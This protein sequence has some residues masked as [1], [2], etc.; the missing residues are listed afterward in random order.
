MIF[1]HIIH[2]NPNNNQALNYSVVFSKALGG[3]TLAFNNNYFIFY[4]QEGDGSGSKHVEPD[5]EIHLRKSNVN[6]YTVEEVEDPKTHQKTQIKILDLVEH[7]YGWA[8]DRCF[9]IPLPK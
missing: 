7:D 8:M 5:S 3:D 1:H 9:G 6:R 2:I 4:T